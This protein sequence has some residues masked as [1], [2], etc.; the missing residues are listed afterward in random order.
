VVAGADLRP[1]HVL[2]GPILVDAED[3]TIW[4]PA[5]MAARV[6]HHGTLM[7]EVSR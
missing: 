1:G 2:A 3:T 6:D 7:M 5:G 4:T